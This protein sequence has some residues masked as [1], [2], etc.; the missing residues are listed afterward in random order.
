MA[1]KALKW[2][3][4]RDP[5]IMLA[6]VLHKAGTRS[7]DKTMAATKETQNTEGKHGCTVQACSDDVGCAGHTAPCG[8][9]MKRRT[10]A[11]LQK[12]GK[13]QNRHTLQILCIKWASQEDGSS[14][15]A[16]LRTPALLVFGLP[17]RQKI[18]SA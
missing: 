18:L 17:C 2:P 10:T 7:R 16:P 9:S 8:C 3:D 6:V 1:T 11:T 12:H 4:G 13:C 14:A 5:G 15:T